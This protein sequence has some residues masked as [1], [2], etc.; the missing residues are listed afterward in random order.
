MVFSGIR[1]KAKEL[2]NKDY[3][4]KAKEKSQNLKQEISELTGEVEESEEITEKVEETGSE[5]GLEKDLSEQRNIF[6]EF[7]TVESDAEEILTL[8]EEEIQ[9]L[10]KGVEMDLK[11]EK[12]I[13]SIVLAFGEEIE[14][15]ERLVSKI[16]ETLQSDITKFNT[17]CFNQ[18]KELGTQ[19]ILDV[20]AEAKERGVSTGLEASLGNDI[21]MLMRENGVDSIGREDFNKLDLEKQVDQYQNRVVELCICLNEVM[22]ELPD[23][24]CVGKKKYTQMEEE[25]AELQKLLEKF[26]EIASETQEAMEE[27]KEIEEFVSL[28]SQQLPG[29]IDELKELGEELQIMGRALKEEEATEKEI[30]QIT[31]K[32]NH[33]NPRKINS[34]IEAEVEKLE[35]NFSKL[36]RH[37]NKLL[38]EA[39]TL[40][41]ENEEL[42]RMEEGEEERITNIIEKSGQVIQDLKTIS[43]RVLHSDKI[44]VTPDDGDSEKFKEDPSKIEYK[45]SYGMDQIASMVETISKEAEKIEEME[46]KEEKMELQIT[47]EDLTPDIAVFN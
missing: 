6:S 33:S 11:R 17:K 2:K 25:L 30:S 8:E 19:G 42:M 16:E 12:R 22:Y 4:G 26:E 15:V 9:N 20:L 45:L 46:E 43:H 29:T 18:A 38:S 7:E 10:H 37:G 34:D 1:D 28:E 3:V 23:R 21:D 41:K 24:N 39:E 35:S 44:A 36:E 5:E 13:K 27:E 47:G 32:M 31:K 14:D 40:E